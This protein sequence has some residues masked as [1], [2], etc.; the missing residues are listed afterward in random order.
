MVTLKQL[1]HATT[2]V[3]Q[4]EPAGLYVNTVNARDHVINTYLAR[5]GSA[6]QPWAAVI[7]Y[8]CQ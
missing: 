2:L 7:Q 8:A 1:D 5:Y 3:R 4:R 6:A